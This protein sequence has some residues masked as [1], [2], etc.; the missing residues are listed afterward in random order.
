MVK[1]ILY[2]FLIILLPLLAEIPPEHRQIIADNPYKILGLGIPCIDLLIPVN[3]DFLKIVPGKKGGAEEINDILL[4]QIIANSG[5]KP[6]MA[7]GGSCSN[8]I[9]G[10]ASIGEPCALLG[11]VGK[12]E[13]SDFF[14]ESVQKAGVIPL[15]L[16]G[17]RAPACVLCLIT[18]EGQRTMRFCEGCSRELTPHQL[19]AEYLQGV[20]LIHLEGYSLRNPNLVEAMMKMAKS[21]KVSVS[22]DLSSFEIVKAFYDDIHSFLTNG[23]VEVLFAN[24]D[25][26]LTLTG[27][28]PEES[29]QQ[30]LQYCK[31]V[32]I[33]R[34]EKGC[35]V[36]SSEGIFQSSAISTD[37][38]DTTGAG[39]LFASGFLYGY[40]HGRSLKEC[41]R[42]GNLLGS[43]V[44]SFIGAEIPEEKWIPLRKII[45]EGEKAK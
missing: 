23:Y 39:D 18:P 30:L 11:T 7:T 35:I 32:V 29:C 28:S 14:Q 16:P 12:G 6:T 10:I 24:E 9:K 36:G 42:Y 27:L 13:W 3:D 41:A 5:V 21:E 15:L 34:G 44:V 38:V 17:T 1:N 45:V 4:K 19:D 43:A 33:L 31:V 2:L 26:S 22:F 8:T 25:E 37:V 40:T 20:K